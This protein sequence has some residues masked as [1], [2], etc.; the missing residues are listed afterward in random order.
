MLSKVVNYGIPMMATGVE[1]SEQLAQIKLMN[2]QYGQGYLFYRPLELAQ[3]EQ[4]FLKNQG[5]AS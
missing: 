3:L 5:I 4:I 2:C 1:T